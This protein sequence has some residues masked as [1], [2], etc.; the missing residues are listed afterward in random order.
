MHSLDICATEKCNRRL[1]EV[2]GYFSHSTLH[3]FAGAQ[4][5]R[6]AG[7]TPVINL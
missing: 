1:V 2:D 4:V 7:P 5:E 3:V 6:N